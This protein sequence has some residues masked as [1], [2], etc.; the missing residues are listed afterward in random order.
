[1]LGVALAL[2]FEGSGPIL[3]RQSRIGRGGQRFVL[4]SFR[5]SHQG[6]PVGEFLR[7][8]RIEGLPQLF[9][10]LW[11]ELTIFGSGRSRP[12]FFMN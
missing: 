11:G 2:G 9:N 10:V 8:T 7:Y 3:H 12:S 5:I 6:S 1:M 4:L